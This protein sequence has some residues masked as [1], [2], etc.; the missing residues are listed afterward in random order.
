MRSKKP[1]E[2]A[3][4][5]SRPY[6]DLQDAPQTGLFCFV[7]RSLASL[8]SKEK[9]MRRF[10]LALTLTCAFSSVALAGHIP[11]SGVAPPPPPPDEITTSGEVPS[12]GITSSGDM[13]AVDLTILLSVLGLVF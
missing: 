11:T 4:D 10:V 8:N 7:T 5:I 1:C 12:V 9:T 2:Y 13:P 6:L 3:R